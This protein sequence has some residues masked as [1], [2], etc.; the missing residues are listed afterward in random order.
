M[1]APV[2]TAWRIVELQMEEASRYGGYINGVPKRCIHTFSEWNKEVLI[3]QTIT[4]IN[5]GT[6]WI[7]E[8]GVGVRNDHRQLRGTAG[9]GEQVTDKRPPKLLLGR[10]HKT[11]QFRAG[12]LWSVAGFALYT[13][14]FK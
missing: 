6:S 2:T 1:W 9:S 3:N 11:F 7:S 13:A 14:S 10:L 8:S 5:I 4:C 12:A